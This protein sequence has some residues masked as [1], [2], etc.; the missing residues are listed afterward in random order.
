MWI[1]MAVKAVRETFMDCLT[2]WITMAILTF[3]NLAVGDMAACTLQFSMHC[4]IYLQ[5][6]INSCMTG[7]TD[8]I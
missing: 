8:R 5:G 6:I 3:R 2:M 4:V 7:C 1:D